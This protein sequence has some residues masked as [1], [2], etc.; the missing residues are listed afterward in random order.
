[1]IMIK[2]YIFVKQ[3]PTKGMLV[4]WENSEKQKQFYPTKALY[5]Y[6]VLNRFKSSFNFFSLFYDI[7]GKIVYT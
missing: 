3:Y 7:F 2:I 6:D 1:M 4:T 5:P